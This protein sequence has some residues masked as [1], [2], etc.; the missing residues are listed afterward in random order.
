VGLA[1]PRDTSPECFSLQPDSETA[2]SVITVTRN[3]SRRCVIGFT[4]TRL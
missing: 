2:H 1:G 3:A 4:C